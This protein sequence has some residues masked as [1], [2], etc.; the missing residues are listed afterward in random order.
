MG[1]L[2]YRYAAV[3]FFHRKASAMKKL[4]LKYSDEEENRWK[5]PVTMK[6]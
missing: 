4:L 1:L 5:I 3:S 2:R 6:I